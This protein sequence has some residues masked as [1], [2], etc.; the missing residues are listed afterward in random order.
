[1]SG[2]AQGRI[3]KTRG[4]S[5]TKENASWESHEGYW[6]R[7]VAK[8]RSQAPKRESSTLE[9]VRVYFTGLK[10]E[11]QYELGR[12]VW[13]HGGEVLPLLSR[14]RVTHVISEQ[15]AASKIEKELGA[16]ERDRVPIVRPQWLLHS[17]EQ[18]KKLPLFQYLLVK[19]KRTN[20]IDKYFSR[21]T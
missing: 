2:P 7:R 19:D 12:R 15:L 10:R 20:G 3:N 14:R 18:G 8:V 1:M 5:K 11:S 4:V 6:S 13:R 16:K 9:G 21:A 17:I